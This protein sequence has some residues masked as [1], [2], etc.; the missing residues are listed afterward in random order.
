MTAPALVHLNWTLQKI[1]HQCSFVLYKQE[2]E[3]HNDK[4]QKKEEEQTFH[5]MDINEV[6]ALK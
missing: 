2:E 3:N 4:Y 6:Q 5:P 1:F